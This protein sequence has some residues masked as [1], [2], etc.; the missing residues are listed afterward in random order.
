M[1]PAPGTYDLNITSGPWAGSGFSG[2]TVT[3]TQMIVPWYAPDLNW[4]ETEGL[5]FS[6]STNTAVEC[7]G[8]GTFDYIVNPG[9]PNEQTGSG[10]CVKTS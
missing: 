10:T 3:A 1:K 4:D 6:P 7:T 9:G 8:T 2:L 5:F